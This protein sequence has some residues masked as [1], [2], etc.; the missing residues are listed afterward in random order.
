[1]RDINKIIVHCSY[2]P[3]SMD[4]GVAE[5]RDWHINDNGWSDIGYHFV[6]GRNGSRQVGRPID[7]AG[8]HVKGHNKDSIG[9]CLVGGKAERSDIAQSNF[10]LAQ[11]KSLDSLLLELYVRFT[12]TSDNV[13]SHYNFSSKEC[14][15]FNASLFA[16]DGTI[17]STV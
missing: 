16:A 3:P 2:T 9:I 1:M 8:A 4:I 11:Y 12:L 6:I 14:P 15:T 7:I 13:F 5:I 10:T 17:V